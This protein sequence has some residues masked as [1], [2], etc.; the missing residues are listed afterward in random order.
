MSCRRPAT[1]GRRTHDRC[2]NN[3][4]ERRLLVQVMPQKKNHHWR[5]SS[6]TNHPTNSGLKYLDEMLLYGAAAPTPTSSADKIS[7]VIEDSSLDICR[8]WHSEYEF[9]T[10]TNFFVSK[11][12]WWE[13]R[14]WYC[15]LTGNKIYGLASLRAIDL[16]LALFI[17]IS[18]APVS[19]KIALIFIVAVL[20]RVSQY[21]AG[22]GPLFSGLRAFML[23]RNN[24]LLALQ[25]NKQ[26]YEI[27]ADLTNSN[28]YI[29]LNALI[30]VGG[31]SIVLSVVS[32]LLRVSSSSP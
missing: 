15:R 18:P 20:A 27:C 17:T 6:D 7:W 30:A 13:A 3:Q 11:N 23:S 5:L 2:C 25:S 28:S 21:F 26:E 9:G 22:H 8:W 29:T 1:C 4:M 14:T 19:W 31:P 12:L 10:T 16:M 24:C 32:K